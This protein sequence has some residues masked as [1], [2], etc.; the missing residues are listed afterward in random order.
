MWAVYR[1]I[2]G[3]ICYWANGCWDPKPFRM[4]RFEN[5]RDA[6]ELARAVN[7]AIEDAK[8]LVCQI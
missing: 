1:E 4:H 7:F 2:N 6:F 3:K 5:Y 8:A